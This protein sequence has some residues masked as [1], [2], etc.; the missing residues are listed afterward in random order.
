MTQA[1]SVQLRSPPTRM[2]RRWKRYDAARASSVAELCIDTAHDVYPYLAR[3]MSLPLDEGRKSRLDDMDG[4]ELTTRTFQGVGT[5]MAIYARRQPLVIVLE[6]LHRADPTSLSATG[7]QTLANSGSDLRGSR[8]FQ[9]QRQ[10]RPQ[11]P[12]IIH[13]ESRDQ[14]EK[15]QG[16]VDQ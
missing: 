9:A 14:V 12:P 7:S 10:Q 16:S 4:Q 15:Q 11:N 13:R 8:M 2:S 1:G 5:L 6:D 3:L